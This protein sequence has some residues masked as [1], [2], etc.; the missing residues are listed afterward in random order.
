MRRH[1]VTRAAPQRTAS[2]VNESLDRP[3]VCHCISWRN[4]YDDS[5]IGYVASL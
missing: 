4:F 1:A 2:D 3:Y 5:G